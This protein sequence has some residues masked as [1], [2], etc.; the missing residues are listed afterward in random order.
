VRRVRPTR[1]LAALLLCLIVAAGVGASARG[2]GRAS[3]DASATPVTLRAVAHDTS[4]PLQAMNRGPISMRIHAPML[5]EWRE[6]VQT[7]GAPVNDPVV[8]RAPG[9]ARMPATT[10][11]FDGLALADAGGASYLP[12]DTSGDVGLTQYVQVVNGMLAVYTKGGSR[13]AGPI[14]NLD[15]WS[16]L[17]GHCDTLAAGDPTVVYDSYANRWVYS[18]FA[19]AIDNQGN[20]V[21]PYYQCV[22]V[23]TSGDATGTWNRYEFLIHSTIFPDY[24]KIAVWHDGYYMSVNQFDDLGFH[25]AGAIVFERSQMLTGGAAQAQYIDASTINPDLGGILPVDADGATAPTGP[26]PFLALVDDPF[27]DANDR[28]QIWHFTVDWA[29]PGNSRFQLASELPVAGQSTGISHVAG[30]LGLDAIGQGQLMYRV[31]WRT[32]GGVPTI[33]ANNTV[34]A[35]SGLAGIRW[36]LLRYVAGNWTLSQQGTYATLSIDRWMGSIAADGT[37]NLALGFTATGGVVNASPYIAGRL[38][39]DPANTLPQSDDAVISSGGSQSHPSQR[40]GDYSQMTVDPADQCTF[41][42]TSEYYAVNSSNNW[43]TRIASFRYAPTECTSTATGQP[44]NT[45]PPGFTGSAIQ[46]LTMNATFGTW[47]G[48]VVSSAYQ[49]RRCD[50]TTGLGCVDI[51]GATVSSYTVAAADIG[52]RLRVRITATNAN[53]STPATSI[54]SPV[55]VPQAPVNTAAPTVSGTVAVGNYLT[56]SNGTWT[57]SVPVTYSHRWERCDSAGANCAPVTGVTGSTY[58]LDTPDVGKRIRGVTIASN[59]GGAATANAAVTIVVPAPPAPAVSASPTIAGTPEVGR[60]LTGGN[61]TWSG[62]G[63]LTFASAWQRCDVDGLNCAAI[64]GATAS[65]YTLTGSDADSTI[66]YAVTATNGGGST[67]ANSLPT[68]T[69]VS[70]LAGGSVGSG[71]GGSG[72]GGSG[73]GGGGGGVAA[74]P[75]W[76]VTLGAA[77]TPKQVGDIFSYIVT[78]TN[79]GGDSSKAFVDV[80]LPSQTS[81]VG[82]SFD[83]GSGCTGTTTLSCNL[84]F[85]PAA[86]TTQIVMAVKVNAEGTLTATANGHALQADLRPADN[87]A[88]LT[89][90][91]GK[92]A[93]PQGAP[94]GLN[95]GSGSPAGPDKVKPSARALSSRVSRGKSSALRFKLYDDRGVAK[96]TATVKRNGKVVATLKTGYGPVVYGTIYFLPWKVSAKLDRGGLSFCVVATDRSGNSSASSCA[97]VSL[98]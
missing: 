60:T 81:F 90:T 55:V 69:V 2:T 73:S 14:P 26:A 29:T 74:K 75:D 67:S 65:T 27:Y 51:P 58:L 41:W 10:T 17:G 52:S 78:I 92:T 8:Q 22:A 35:G 23:S 48:G 34:D 98:R 7:V 25:G 33:V 44:T 24:P 63:T 42:F 97:P 88:T 96:A 19:F 76:V 4:A 95:G 56:V 79:K 68:A 13:V 30:G 11:N 93:Q 64:S 87:I 21:G 57:S 28:L 18:E 70:P 61:G 45:T 12:P 66:R 31:Q 85:L 71:S 3:R 80:T 91:I 54:A 1:I 49:W 50:G 15:F 5:N 59:G 47:A 37:G 32:I 6:R 9:S 38:T 43:R 89:L 84:D 83:R 16:G 72:S 86:M 82:A 36:Y 20:Q 39:T 53:G 46:D 40:W 77:P 62:L 94:G